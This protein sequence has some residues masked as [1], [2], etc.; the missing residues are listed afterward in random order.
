[1]RLLTFILFAFSASAQFP[2]T[3]LMNLNTNSLTAGPAVWYPTNLANCVAWWVADDA[4]ASGSV[5]TNIPDRWVNG[6]AFTNRVTGS[7]PTISN[8][9]LNGHTALLFDGVDDFIR[10]PYSLSQPE[11]VWLFYMMLSNASTYAWIISDFPAGYGTSYEKNNQNFGVL[12]AGSAVA[13]VS[14]QFITNVYSVKTLVFDGN[15]SRVYNTNILEVSGNGGANAMTGF[16][17]GRY[18]IYYSRMLFLELVTYSVT[19]TFLD[20]SNLFWYFTNK[21]GSL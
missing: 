1:M 5:A 21:Y 12:Y 6:Y 16:T 3:L 11:E 13:N 2:E 18:D 8:S 15:N 19:N 20:R 9:W 14:Y 7:A 4:I 10:A 17:L